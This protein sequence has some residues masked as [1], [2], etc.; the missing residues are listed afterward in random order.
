[1]DAELKATRSLEAGL[2][3][4]LEA[5]TL[6]VFYQPQFGLGNRD[7]R[8]VEALV[9]WPHTAGGYVPPSSFI[10]VAETSGLIV[11]LGEWVLR[12]A[13]RQAKTWIDAGW[14]FRIAV[15]LSVVQLRQPDFCAVL[16]R[17]LDQSGLAAASLEIEVTEN[18]F[19]DASKAVI[20]RTLHQMAAMG[21]HLAID[22]FGTGYSSL[23]YL[24]HFPFDRIKIDQSFVRDIG[25]EANADAI[26]KAIIALGRS[27]GKSVTAEGVETVRQL[28][29]LRRNECDEAQ[30]FLLARPGRARDVEPAFATSTFAVTA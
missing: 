11:P 30:G 15:N 2:R 7:L 27:L 26:V 1:M 5:Q 14:R 22:D 4:A 19:L 6:E 10:P 8:G 3:Q 25:T 12:Q 18:V 20:V 17:I 24:R 29:F 23:S 13:C 21:V 9:R 16:K 28:A